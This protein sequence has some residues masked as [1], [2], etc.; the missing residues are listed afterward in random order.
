M[1]NWVIGIKVNRK[2]PGH[3]AHQLGVIMVFPV[4]LRN[5]RILIKAPYSSEIDILL[6]KKDLIN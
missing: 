4:S 2:G 6:S 3:G 5:H 1:K